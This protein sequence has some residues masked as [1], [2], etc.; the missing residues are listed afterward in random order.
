MKNSHVYVSTDFFL[1]LSCLDERLKII[2][3]LLK[4][5]SGEYSIATQKDIANST[6]LGISKVRNYLK[7]LEENNI[8]QRHSQGIYRLSGILLS[9]KV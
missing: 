3:Y 6:G 9:Q 2:D 1:S 5:R 7:L 4:N 8:I